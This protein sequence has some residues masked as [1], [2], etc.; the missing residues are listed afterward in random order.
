MKNIDKNAHKM[1]VFFPYHQDSNHRVKLSHVM[2]ATPILKWGNYLKLISL[3]LGP[4][5]IVL[6]L[7]P[8]CSLAL[9]LYFCPPMEAS[10]MRPPLAWIKTII[11][12]L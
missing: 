2:S 3:T 4:L 11:P 6:F 10:Y 1:G 5:S 8:Y 12:F 7:L 9:K